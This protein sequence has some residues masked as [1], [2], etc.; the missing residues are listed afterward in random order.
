MVDEFQ[1]EWDNSYKNKDN[2]IF[3]PHEEVVRFI[4]K[5]IRKR[6]GFDIFLDQCE[7]K[8]STKVLDFGCGIGRHM[9]LLY[10][11]G[12]NAR[13]FDLSSEAIEVAKSNFSSLGMN[14]VSKKLDIANIINLPYK[15]EEFDFMLSHGVIDSM[16]ID[17]AQKGFLE[18]Y[19]TLKKGGYIF[20]DVI[21]IDDPSLSSAEGEKYRIVTEDHEQGTIQ[22]YFDLDLVSNLLGE[23]FEISEFYN[24]KKYCKNKKT[25]N[26]RYYVIAKK[27]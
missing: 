9:K 27:I 18:L 5:Y 25:L 1:S 16:P 22:S 26:S 8:E 6:V 3:Y 17:V 4:S 20:F 10:E 11:F 2:Y 13:G 23:M 12:L 21:G 19:R 14:E 15:S 24:I 7:I